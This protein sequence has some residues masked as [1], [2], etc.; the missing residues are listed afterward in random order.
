[1]QEN[2]D[3]KNVPDNLLKGLSV[4][5]TM[6]SPEVKKEVW[7]NIE[8]STLKKK[9]QVRFFYRY[10]AVVILLVSI[11]LYF[12]LNKKETTK[13]DYQ[14]M[15][16][17]YFA[18]EKGAKNVIIVLPNNEKIELEEKNVEL[19]HDAEGKMS[20]NSKV[21]KEERPPKTTDIAY[22]QILVPYGKTS[23]IVMSDGTKVW[24]NSGS[25][26]VYPA[27]FNEKQR[28]IY[29]EGEVYL[30]VAH[31]P[32]CPFIVKTEELEVS[33]LGTSFNISAYK[34]DS[35]QS[36]AL[37]TGSVSVKGINQKNNT[38]IKPNQKYTFENDTKQSRLEDAD[39]SSD[40]SWKY[41]FLIFE[42][43]KLDKVLKKIE[44]YYNKPIYY[45]PVEMERY[46]VS[47]KLDLKENI[48]ETFRV[49]SITAPI[50]YKIE[51]AGINVNL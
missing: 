35:F 26:V 36:V 9:L 22:Q 1:M 30:E 2:L 51:E 25:R 31:K 4:E 17:E 29:M 14:S 48:N 44:R 47:G 40:V 3:D 18:D 12:Y 13:I 37:A 23:N 34:N 43:E 24:V 50:N 45:N 39:I 6:I 15:I 16:T 32:D 19:I 7:Q 49:I 33:V 11:P 41:G 20:I 42:K 27:I 21:V 28:E 5:E 8:T 38:T 46:T 10:A